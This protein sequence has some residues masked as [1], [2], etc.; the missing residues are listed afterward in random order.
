MDRNS[1]LTRRSELLSV[2]NGQRAPLAPCFSGLI[3]CVQG[4]LSAQAVEWAETFSLPEALANA[5]MS[6]AEAFGGCSAT[7]P[8]D[9]CVE[10][11][12]LG[13]KLDSALHLSELQFPAISQPV[14]E[15]LSD[16]PLQLPQNWA[17]QGRIPLVVQAIARVRERLGERGVL[18]ACI[19]GP[20][21]LAMQLIAPGDLL[22]AVTET[23]AQVAEVL[24]YC[25]SVLAETANIYRTAGA[26]F[27]TVHEMGGSPGYLGPR[28]FEKLVFPALQAL[29]A[30][31][32]TPRVLSVC[33]KAERSLA[34]LATA[35]V[36]ALSFDQ[37]TPLLV[38]RAQL[39]PQILLF[40]NLDPFRLL[41]KSSPSEI[42]AA[43]ASARA[44]GADAVW[45]GCDLWLNTPAENV[46][47]F[48]RQ[49]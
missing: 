38:A 34:L 31:I 9:I 28:P 5:A 47:A 37:L 21:T 2:L 16:L 46:S 11:E 36:E 39:P 4:G 23:P 42:Q 32:P 14:C 26:D 7:L 12:A 24:R 18:S 35:H 29:L 15:K 10:A 1:P 33:G 20:F 41:A 25:S 13:A 27:V 44:D 49:T 48:F 45:P 17:K 40:G 43:I 19:P 3:H 6:T 30:Q 8:L 22:L